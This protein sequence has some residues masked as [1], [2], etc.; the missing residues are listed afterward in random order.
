MGYVPLRR[1]DT[2]EEA[3]A[4]AADM[5]ARSGVEWD[6]RQ[7][8]EYGSCFGWDVPAADVDQVRADCYR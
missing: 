2:P 3:S 5:N 8:M 4:V 1:Y 7:A 6:Q